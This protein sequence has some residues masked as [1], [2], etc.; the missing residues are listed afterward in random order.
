MTLQD[1]FDFSVQSLRPLC[2]CC[3]FYEPLVNH[4]GIEDTEIAQRRV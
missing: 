2:L 1:E 3:C 4:R